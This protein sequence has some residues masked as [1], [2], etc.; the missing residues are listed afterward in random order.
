MITFVESSGNQSTD[1]ALQRKVDRLLRPTQV[2]LAPLQDAIR[3]GFAQNFD[4]ESAGGT[5]WAAIAPSTVAQRLLLGFGAGP[6]LHRTGSY[7]D[8][9]TQATNPDHA[10]E[11]EYSSGVTTLSEGGSHPLTPFLEM[12]TGKMPARPVLELSTS[13]INEISEAFDK[14]VS[15]ILNG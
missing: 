3:K 10:S 6:I 12:G 11:I 1:A 7:Q 15:G 14:M 13:A 8:A 9:F 4:T 5:P 2:D